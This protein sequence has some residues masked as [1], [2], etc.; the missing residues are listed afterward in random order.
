MKPGDILAAA[1]EP[2]RPRPPADTGNPFRSRKLIGL[3]F[4]GFVFLAV[5]LTTVALR[6]E[7]MVT[8]VLALATAFGGAATA[9]IGTQGLADRERERRL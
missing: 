3:F 6:L 1:P 9:A 8:V 4:T 2:P 7:W 5:F